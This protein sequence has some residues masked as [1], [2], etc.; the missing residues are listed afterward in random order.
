MRIDTTGSDNKQ[1]NCC[2]GLAANERRDR[3]KGV[4]AFW[5]TH[6]KASFPNLKKVDCLEG[7]IVFHFPWYKL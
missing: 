1:G 2:G 4:G 3:K 6:E 7:G 5:F